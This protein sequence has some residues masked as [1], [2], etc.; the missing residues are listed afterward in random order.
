MEQGSIHQKL[1]KI[2][3]EYRKNIVV[4][5]DNEY[6][7]RTR[8]G[9]RI[10]DKVAAFGGSWGFIFSFA[11]F[12][13]LWLVW[14]ILP[15]VR[16]FDPVPFILLNLILS[17]IAGFQAPFIM[18]AQNRHAARDKVEA[19]IDFAIN[20]RSEIEIEEIQGRLKVIESKLTSMEQGV[21]EIRRMLSA[22]SRRR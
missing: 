11:A 4:N 8:L 7:Q 6:I 21:E 10:A 17:F 5:L 18:M 19:D 2:L 15:G 14:N 20:Y 1:N 22:G 16:H 13:L 12:L 9:E 3:E